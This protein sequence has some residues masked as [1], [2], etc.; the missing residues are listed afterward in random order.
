MLDY[1]RLE[2]VSPDFNLSARSEKV[3]HFAEIYVRRTGKFQIPPT[4]PHDVGEVLYY[5]LDI[6]IVAGPHD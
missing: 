5:I 1:M 4:S 3:L 2:R 6:F